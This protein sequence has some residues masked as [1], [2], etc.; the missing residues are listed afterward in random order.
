[1][2]LEESFEAVSPSVI[3]FGSRMTWAPVGQ[4]PLFP[5]IFGTGF[6]VHQ[7]GI[8]VTNR[9]VIE[10]FNQIPKNPK[11][12]ESSLAAVMFIPGGDGK[13]QQMLPLEIKGWSAL[14]S[15]SSS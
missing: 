9:H 3:G 15:F 8:A 6:L 12:G 1:M 10:M 2:T 11:T 4:Q 13:S 5:P 14:G 7:D